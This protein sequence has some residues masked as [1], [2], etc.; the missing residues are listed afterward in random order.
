MVGCP[1]WQ[2]WKLCFTA[3]AVN[4]WMVGLAEPGLWVGSKH[5]LPAAQAE[6]RP[7]RS[8]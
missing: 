3:A 2:R 8:G 1:G 7:A 5:L 4:L 6:G